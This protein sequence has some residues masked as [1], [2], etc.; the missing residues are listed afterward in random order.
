MNLSSVIGRACAIEA[1]PG[2]GSRIELQVG[3]AALTRHAVKHG[4][5]HTAR[6]I[7]EPAVI[8]FGI[9]EVNDRDND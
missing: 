6:A 2:R 5:S 3:H 7:S 4:L 8:V 9:P 1:R